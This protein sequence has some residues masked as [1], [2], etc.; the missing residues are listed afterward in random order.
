M[1]NDS[2]CVCCCV[3]KHEL[4]QQ[5]NL[6]IRE[7]ENVQVEGDWPVSTYLSTY[8]SE[9]SLMTCHEQMN[10]PHGQQTQQIWIATGLQYSEGL[11]KVQ[12]CCSANLLCS[13]L[14]T[15]INPLG[16]EGSSRTRVKNKD[17]EENSALV[18]RGKRGHF[19]VGQLIVEGSENLSS[20]YCIRHGE[21]QSQKIGNKLRKAGGETMNGEYW[22]VWNFT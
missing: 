20:H 10:M 6:M 9:M 17:W 7:N 4:W 22:E 19:T 11:E 15:Q 5:G 1:P 3:L 18:M 8:S 16:R 13:T 2:F 14:A 21:M 12:L